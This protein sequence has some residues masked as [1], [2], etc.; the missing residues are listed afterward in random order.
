VQA[1]YVSAC[2]S[3]MA[4]WIIEWASRRARG[5]LSRGDRSSGSRYRDCEG[6]GTKEVAAEG[7]SAEADKQKKGGGAAVA[8]VTCP[9]H[10]VACASHSLLLAA[11]LCA[12]L[13]Q[14]P[15]QTQPRIVVLLLCLTLSTRRALL[16]SI[17]TSL[18]CPLLVAPAAA[19]KACQVP[20]NH[21]L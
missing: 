16:H 2:L 9:K 6:G 19:L 21:S 15:Y 18:L 1:L 11:C 17:D 7:A 10:H 3:S 8:K 12:A 20:H 5:F 14:C 4:C 13:L